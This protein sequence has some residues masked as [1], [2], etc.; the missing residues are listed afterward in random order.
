MYLVR[1][2]IFHISLTLS[3][4]FEESVIS[5]EEIWGSRTINDFSQGRG[6]GSVVEHLPSMCTA[7]GV[8]PSNAKAINKLLL[9]KVTWP[10]GNVPQLQ[11]KYLLTKYTCSLPTTLSCLFLIMWISEYLVWMYRGT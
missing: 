10:I 8:T 6:C 7:L 9:S 1:H 5:R 3:N 4:L 2:F 11:F